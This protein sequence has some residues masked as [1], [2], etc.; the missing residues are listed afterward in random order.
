MQRGTPIRGCGISRSL[1][2]GEKIEHIH[3][4]FQDDKLSP[5]C[6]LFSRLNHKMIKRRSG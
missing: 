4:Q 6:N 2:V 1:D 5:H 3:F